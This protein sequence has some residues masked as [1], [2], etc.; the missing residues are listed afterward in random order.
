MWNALTYLGWT[1]L[2]GSFLYFGVL[3]IKNP[4][5]DN[6]DIILFP[7]QHFPQFQQPSILI[8]DPAES[9]TK[10]IPTLP[11]EPTPPGPT[12]TTPGAPTPPDDPEPSP[13]TL[14]TPSPV[15]TT[16]ETTIPTT[17]P[18]TPRATIAPTPPPITTTPETTT[19]PTTTPQKTP[20]TTPKTT[21]PPTTTPS[22]TESTA[23]GEDFSECGVRTAG[24]HEFRGIE[25][26]QMDQYERLLAELRIVGGRETA[27]GEWP[28][29]VHIYEKDLGIIDGGICSATLISSRWIVTAA[30]CIRTTD[31]SL[32]TVVMG[33]HRKSETSGFEVVRGLTSL[34][35]HPKFNT[36]TL[37][38]DIAVALLDEEV[39]LD[40]Y[41]RPACLVAP[42]ETYD[43]YSPHIRYPC[44]TL[45]WG[46]TD[47]AFKEQS[48]VLQQ[49]NIQILP[50]HVCEMI[51]L[52]EQ[53]AY[54]SGFVGRG[55]SKFCAGGTSGEDT[56]DGDSGGPLICKHEDGKFYLHGITSYGTQTCA[57]A[58]KPAIFT[59][60]SD[61]TEWIQNTT[62]LKGY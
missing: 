3:N 19:A 26:R 38:N 22:T 27:D 16:P 51:T 18:T 21:T 8:V 48:D 62:G 31:P 32:Y 28:W 11:T 41:I 55:S 47:P 30:H 37:N 50:Q 44:T 14:T 39:V 5:T 29:I 10:V 53:E 40:A 23:P 43:D 35:V 57:Q 54:S 59:K 7:I 52:S 58:A 25:H 13:E 61:L 49:L 56:C 33:E 24:R 60:V 9:T 46:S 15:T 45:G 17:A 42:G 2:N 36:K 6:I 1:L 12:P 4:M 20:K 34:H